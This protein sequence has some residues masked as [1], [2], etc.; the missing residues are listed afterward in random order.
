M[1]SYGAWK[2]RFG[3]DPN[4]VGRNV[5][6]DGEPYTV[7]GVM[8][9]RFP[10]TFL[11]AELWTPLGITKSAPDDG[12]TNIVTI[13]QLADGVTFE[14]ANAEVARVVRGIARELPRTHQGWTGG[15]PRSA[16]GS[17][18]TFRAPLNVLFCGVLRA[19]AHRLVQH[20]EPDA[21]ERDLA[22]QRALAAPRDWREPM[23]GGAA[24]A[25]GNCDAS[26]PPAP[27]SR[28]ALGAWLLPVLLAIAPTTTHAL[29]PVT[30][31]WRVALFAAACAVMSSLIAGLVPAFT[32]SDT[33][34]RR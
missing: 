4:I 33:A 3:G 24:R 16:T 32:A 31:D 1:L 12:R 18:A 27:R 2:R 26:T 13:A 7:I 19:A 8:P 10:P 28:S 23:G 9:N 22:Q 29:G 15:I 20:R 6:L 30:I 25:P 5:Q 17:T 21:R 11:N 14:Q 34:P